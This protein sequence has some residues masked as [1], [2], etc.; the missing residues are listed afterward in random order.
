MAYITIPID[1]PEAEDEL[2]EAYE[3]LCLK[4][5]KELSLKEAINMGFPKERFKQ[6]RVKWSS[7]KAACEIDELLWEHFGRVEH[8][9]TIEQRKKEI[10][11]T[12]KDLETTKDKI[13]YRLKVLN[14]EL[15]GLERGN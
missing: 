10:Q 8:Y 12:T 2:Y 15:D 13:E 6:L 3:K 9:K 14:R 5:K 7:F 1:L 11:Q 4:A